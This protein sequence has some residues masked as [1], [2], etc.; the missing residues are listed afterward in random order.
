MYR[1]ICERAKENKQILP[2]ESL[3][4]IFLGCAC[5]LQ[6]F[7]GLGSNPYHSSDNAKSLTARPPRNSYFKYQEETGRGLQ[8]QDK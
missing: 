3:K 4:Y 8:S 1:Y 6:K 2:L 7:P 5:S